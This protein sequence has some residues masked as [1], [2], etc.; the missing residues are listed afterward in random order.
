MLKRLSLA[1]YALALFFGCGAQAA[2]IRLGETV[3]LGSADNGNANLLMGNAPYGLTQPA[4]IKSLS[5]YVTTASGH[6]TLGIYDSGPNNDCAGGALRAQTN[7]FAPGSNRWNTANVIT[8]AQ[9]PVG[10]YC[11]VALPS[12]NN[13]GFVKGISTGINDYCANFTFGSMPAMFPANPFCKD[14]F[15]WSLYAT[16]TPVTAPTLSLSFNPSAPSVPADTPAGTVVAAITAQW[17]NG[18][19]FTGTLSFGSPNFSDGGTFAVDGN[20]NLIVSSTGP[21][22]SADAGTIQNTTIIATQ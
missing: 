22:L 3:R 21:G 8:Q 15:H 7:S 12:S 10:N 13:L 11:L 1:L 16:L 4:T 17:S 6:L 5:F 9:L 18:Q 2:D 14:R 20:S 19:P